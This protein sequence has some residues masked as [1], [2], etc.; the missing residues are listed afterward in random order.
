MNPDALL[1]EEAYHLMEAIQQETGETVSELAGPRTDQDKSSD[2]LF[3]IQ[4]HLQL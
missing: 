3:R 1:L 4:S 2:L